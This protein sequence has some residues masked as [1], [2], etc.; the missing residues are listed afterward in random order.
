MPNAA[1]LYRER[2]SML[3]EALAGEDAASAREQVRASIDEVP[4]HPLPY[5]PE[6]GAHD[7]GR[8]EGT[9]AGV[10]RSTR[11]KPLTLWHQG[12][13]CRWLRGR[14]TNLNC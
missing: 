1:E 7:R 5:R 6:G 4:G 12:L 3:R 13:L 14:A 8:R 9:F 2:V 11:R 10:M